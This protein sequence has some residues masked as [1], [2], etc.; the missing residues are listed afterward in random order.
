MP[1][2]SRSS[3]PSSSSNTNKKNKNVSSPNNHP[4]KNNNNLMDTST[5]AALLTYKDPTFLFAVS[6]LLSVLFVE[7]DEPTMTLRLKKFDPF[8]TIAHL[9]D[10]AILIGVMV[11][12]CTLKFAFDK[13][14]KQGP[15]IKFLRAG[16]YLWNAC[17][18]HITM[19]GLGS[20]GFLPLMRSNYELLD[21]R[22]KPDD[23]N[24]K[25]A[26]QGLHHASQG[27]IALLDFIVKT[28]L[29]V[30]SLFCLGAFFGVVTE[31]KFRDEC[32]IIASLL[33]IAGTLVWS[34]PEIMVGCINCV[35]IGKVGCIPGTSL[36]E[37]FYYW[38]AFGINILWVIV[39]GLCLSAAVERSIS[40]KVAVSDF[41][42]KKN[43]DSN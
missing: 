2:S 15:R 33:H 18:F 7:G 34:V 22:L 19:D 24:A 30:M 5:A 23:V 43:K 32:E 37:L 11:A 21:A 25:R 1:P 16:W 3:S 12:V 26:A 13:G 38:F 14:I 27:E 17:F 4:N 28:E 41:I 40:V 42:M 39:P 8:K 9:L 31:A 29:Y 10:P 20:I 6:C 36:Y 35:P